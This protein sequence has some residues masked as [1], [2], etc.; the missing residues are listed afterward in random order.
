MTSGVS[1]AP[2]GTTMIVVNPAF[3]TRNDGA[4]TAISIIT[5]V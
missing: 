4:I 2:H 5:V 1:I 3:P